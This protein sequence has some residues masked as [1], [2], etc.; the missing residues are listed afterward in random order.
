MISDDVVMSGIPDVCASSVSSYTN[1]IK[2]EK[3]KIT[4]LTSYIS[5]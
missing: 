2:L 1:P 5:Y 4:M 3:G